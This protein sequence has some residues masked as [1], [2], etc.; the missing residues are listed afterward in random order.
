MLNLV[1]HSAYD[2]QFDSDHRF[3]MGKYTALMQELEH[4]ERLNKTAARNC[5]F[6]NE[7]QLSSP[8]IQALNSRRNS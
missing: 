2:A 8:L 6:I 7:V 3:P 4:S 1:H 5:I